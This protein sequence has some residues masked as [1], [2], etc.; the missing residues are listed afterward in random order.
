MLAT[1]YRHGKRILILTLTPLPF[2]IY[3]RGSHQDVVDNGKTAFTAHP[4]A[5]L[6]EDAC[7]VKDSCLVE[8]DA[9]AVD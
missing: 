7:I 1:E 6:C 8:Q 9:S 3:T 2:I 5:I 4:L